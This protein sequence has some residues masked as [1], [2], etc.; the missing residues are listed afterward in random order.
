MITFDKDNNMILGYLWNFALW[1]AL[2]G[3]DQDLLEVKVLYLTTQIMNN[4][5]M[6]ASSIKYCISFTS[7]LIFT[8]TL[9]FRVI[10]F[11]TGKNNLHNLPSVAHA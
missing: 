10:L 9:L 6:S 3:L 1:E 7:P 8:A 4:N 11:Y 5:L 2:N